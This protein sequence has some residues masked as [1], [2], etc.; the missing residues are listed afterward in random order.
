MRKYLNNSYVKLMAGHLA[1]ILLMIGLPLT[2]ILAATEVWA[3]PFAMLAVLSIVHV[4]ILALQVSINGRLIPENWNCAFFLPL[5]IFSAQYTVNM[6]E[7]G[8]YAWAVLGF[9]LT[10]ASAM[11][12]VLMVLNIWQKFKNPKRNS[13]VV[14]VKRVTSDSQL[15]DEEP[16]IY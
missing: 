16:M 5:P 7:T 1:V 14:A 11:I 8:L 15:P 9:L 13:T 12:V 2:I 6:A 3:L 4:A 10:A